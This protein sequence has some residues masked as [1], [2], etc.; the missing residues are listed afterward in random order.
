MEPEAR[1]PAS[2]PSDPSRKGRLQMIS[3]RFAPRA[4]LGVLLTASALAAPAAA[5]PV[6]VKLRVEG[7]HQTTFEDRVTT[8][9][10][11]NGDRSYSVA[12]PVPY[13]VPTR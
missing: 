1:R 12:H 11:Q 8:E 2:G 6:S 13:P 7:A 9:L 5:T 4:L 10:P 3:I